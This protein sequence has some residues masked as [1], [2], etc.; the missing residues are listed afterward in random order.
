MKSKTIPVFI[1]RIFKKQ[2]FENTRFN[3]YRIEFDDRLLET[4]DPVISYA[5]GISLVMGTW[6]VLTNPVSPNGKQRLFNDPQTIE[7]T[8]KY[9]ENKEDVMI[10][11][12][13]IWIPNHIFLAPTHI[14]KINQGDVYRISAALFN[15]CY[16]YV[17]DRIDHKEWGH[18]TKS[19]HAEM[20]PSHK[21]TKAFRKWRTQQ[22]DWFRYLYHKHDYKEFRLPQKK[23]QK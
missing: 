23:L 19:K 9:F 7:E 16:Q 15:A 4:S 18:K 17:S 14:H 3:F 11:I 21:E 22:I 12:G 8:F 1:D 20:K 13:H 2:G 5:D 10:E 6:A